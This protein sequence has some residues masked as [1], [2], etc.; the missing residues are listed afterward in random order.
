MD[1]MGLERTRLT[2]TALHLSSRIAFGIFITSYGETE[3]NATG[4]W[5]VIGEG[6]CQQTSGKLNL[7]WFEVASYNDWTNMIN[8]SSFDDILIYMYIYNL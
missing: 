8:I 6:G 4:F 2:L 5:L 7:Q 3:F 1:P